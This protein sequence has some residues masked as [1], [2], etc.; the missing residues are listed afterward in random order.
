M[1]AQHTATPWHRNIKPATK[2]PVIFAGQSTHIAQVVARG[3]PDEEV[4]AN[5]EFIVRACNAHDEMLKTLLLVLAGLRNGNIK[6]KP[7]IDLSDMNAES[8]PMM[9]LAQVVEATLAKATGAA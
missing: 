4:E 2:Y 7:I 5:L 9:S 8:V 6:A 1:K 3:L